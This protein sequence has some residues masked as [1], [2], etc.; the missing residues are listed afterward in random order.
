MKNF[1]L[2][3]ILLLFNACSTN[4]TIVGLYGKCEKGYFACTQIE[5]KSDKTFDYFNF[6]DVG[7]GNVI[8]GTWYLLTKDTIVLNSFKQPKNPTTTFTSKTNPELKEKIRIKIMDKDGPVEMVSV[9]I[10]DTK[11]LST[12]NSDGIVEFDC[13]LLKK[14]EY[15][16]LSN[17]EII[18]I[19][20]PN[21][22]EIEIL[23][24]DLEYGVMDFF[25]NYKLLVKN[26]RIIIESGKS[27]KKTNMNE[28]QWN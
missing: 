18:N 15:K 6:M 8:K 5:L 1:K 12:T 22:N 14:I 13:K 7:G 21:Y 27:L 23:I 19:Y 9:Q 4:K 11:L 24:K 3:L 10:N 25:R 28:K 2:I 20:N 17:H 16:I 26:K